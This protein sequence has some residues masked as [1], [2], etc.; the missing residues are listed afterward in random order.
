MVRV[1]LSTGPGIERRSG[2]GIPDAGVASSR[3]SA[4]SAAG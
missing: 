4:V 3:L 2:R 1:P